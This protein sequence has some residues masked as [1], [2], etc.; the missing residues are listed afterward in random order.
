MSRPVAPMDFFMPISRVRSVTLISMVVMT[1]IPDTASEIP[2]TS[3]S[4]VVTMPR[5]SSSCPFCARRLLTIYASAVP[6]AAF[7][8]CFTASTTGMSASMSSSFTASL[9]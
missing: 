7:S 6:F 5:M 3:E 2:A 9:S 8:A 1:E 4:A